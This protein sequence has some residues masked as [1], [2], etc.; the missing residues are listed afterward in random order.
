M[1]MWLCLPEQHKSTGSMSSLSPF[2][3]SGSRPQGD[4]QKPQGP[5][6]PQ[7]R[8]ATAKADFN[9]TTESGMT[10][11]QHMSPEAAHE[12]GERLEHGPL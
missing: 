4:G 3:L 12:R 9:W 2:L 5:S 1:S 7:G 10:Q 11:K 6:R 8:Q